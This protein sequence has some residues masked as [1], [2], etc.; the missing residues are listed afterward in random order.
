MFSTAWIT[1]ASS[2]IGRA[3][4]LRLAGQGVKVAVSGRTEESLES[5]ARE[6]EALPGSCEPFPMDVTEVEA[7]RATVREIEAQMGGIDLALF[8]AGT[9]EDMSGADFSAERAAKVMTVNYLG[10]VNA[11]DAVLPAMRGRARGRIGVV[12]SVAGYRG[13]PGLAAY[14]PSKAALINLCESIHGDLKRDGIRLTLFSPGFVKTRLTE[15]AMPTPFAI[16]PER[17][18][19]EIVRG[20]SSDCFEVIFPKELAP[21]FIAGR[22]MPNRVYLRLAGLLGALR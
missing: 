11:L 1:G 14:G 10:V 5:L 6:A 3:T 21:Q 17:A 13:F 16:T 2:G 18:A 22:V 19:K 8:A 4:A 9:H 7:C 12:G 20:L 15:R